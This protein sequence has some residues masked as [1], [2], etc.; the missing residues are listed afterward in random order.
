MGPIAFWDCARLK[1][2]VRRL[3]VT[4]PRCAEGRSGGR[5]QLEIAMGPRL[6][7]D[8]LW[9]GTGRVFGPESDCAIHA[10]SSP[11]IVALN[12]MKLFTDH[13]VLHD[14]TRGFIPSSLGEDEKDR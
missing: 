13:G 10:L 5:E 3:P 6:D 8:V 2:P 12:H 9:S 7:A 14:D 4:R 1:T 11:A